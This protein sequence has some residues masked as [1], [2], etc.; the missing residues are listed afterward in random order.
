M[1]LLQRPDTVDSVMSE[2][3]ASARP[4]STVVLPRS[5]CL[6]LNLYWVV[7]VS[8]DGIVLKIISCDRVSAII[9]SF[10]SNFQSRTDEVLMCVAEFR[11]FPSCSYTSC[12]N[13]SCVANVLV[14][15]VS[16][17]RR[18]FFLSHQSTP[19]TCNNHVS[20]LS[21]LFLSL[22]CQLKWSCWFRVSCAVRIV[23]FVLVAY[24]N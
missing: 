5:V 1:F 12:A 17:S 21:P 10:I 4:A 9:W 19:F 14:N 24:V 20:A 15:N 13:S 7:V 23:S 3:R 8:W 22:F 11:A 6:L 2:S 18:L 16:N